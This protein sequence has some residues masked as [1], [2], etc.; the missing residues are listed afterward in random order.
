MYT[1][2]VIET[3]KCVGTNEPVNTIYRCPALVLSVFSTSAT[4]S[5]SIDV[6]EVGAEQLIAVIRTA[7]G[8]SE[9]GRKTLGFVSEVRAPH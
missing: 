5:H 8:G 9:S 7:E 4:S 1:L 6:A 3:I 2:A